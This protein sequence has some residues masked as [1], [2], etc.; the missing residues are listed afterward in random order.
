[1]SSTNAAATKES[2]SYSMTQDMSMGFEFWGFSFSAG[3]SNTYASALEVDTSREFSSS[4]D[5]EY[6]IACTGGEGPENG[7]GLWQFVVSNGD[8]SVVT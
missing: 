4:V 2:M 6:E 7:V 8:S 5:I 1:M 3:I